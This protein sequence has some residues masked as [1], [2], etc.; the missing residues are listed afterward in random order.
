MGGDDG[1]HVA[2]LL[3]LLEARGHQRV[4]AAE[5]VREREGRRLPHVADA[6]REQEAGERRLLAPLECRDEIGRRLRAHA[7]EAGQLLFAQGVQVGR[8]RDATRIDQLLDDLVA[9]TLDVHGAA[10]REVAQRLASLGLADEPARAAGHRLAFRT[11]HV[12]GADGA[13]RR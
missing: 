5:M 11:S 3:D 13:A 7:L 12:R 8:R 10:R 4:E 2:N 1:T 9:E 6:E